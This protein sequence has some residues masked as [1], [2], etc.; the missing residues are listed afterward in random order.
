M[1]KMQAVAPTLADG[2]STWMWRRGERREI[3]RWVYEDRGMVIYVKPLIL[4]LFFKKNLG[5][6]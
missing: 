6:L 2:A 5:Y 4:L 1:G 3:D